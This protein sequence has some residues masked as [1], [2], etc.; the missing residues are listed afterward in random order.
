MAE[1]SG[2]E[3]DTEVIKF[4]SLTQDELLPKA[5]EKLKLDPDENVVYIESPQP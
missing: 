2:K 1:G 4:S 5:M 3:I